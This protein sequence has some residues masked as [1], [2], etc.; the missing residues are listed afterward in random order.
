MLTVSFMNGL[1]ILIGVGMDE[2]RFLRRRFGLACRALLRHTGLGSDLIVEVIDRQ[3]R[4]AEDHAVCLGTIMRRHPKLSD[5]FEISKKKEM[6]EPRN[7]KTGRP[8]NKYIV[9]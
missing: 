1:R 6:K 5:F 3:D 8:V 7:P 2:K 4:G 9:S